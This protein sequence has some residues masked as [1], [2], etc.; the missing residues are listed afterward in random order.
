MKQYTQ[1]N[2]EQRYH[3]SGLR[4]SGWNQTQIASELGV[5]KSTISREF[6]RNKGLRG[7]RPKHAQTMRDERKQTSINGKQLLLN[8]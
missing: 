8:E 1:F 7:W 6:S 2:Q 5:N 3:I 4:K